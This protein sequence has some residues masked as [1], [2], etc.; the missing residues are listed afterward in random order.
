[1]RLVTG[2]LIFFMYTSVFAIEPNQW[3]NFQ[4]GTT[5]GWGS[6]APNPNPPVVIIDGG[7]S[8]TGDAYLLV[9]S[10]GTSGAGSMLITY[11]I[12][13]WSGDF[14]TAG[15]TT[16]SMHMN[17]FNS[18]ELNMRVVLQGPGGNFWSV[19]PVNLPAQS[20]WQV[21][22]FSLLPADLTGG[23]NYNATLS[24]V[25]QFR[26]IH[27]PVGSH[28][29][30]V[31]DAELGVDNITAAADPLPVELIS[32]N[33]FQ[34]NNTIGLNWV[35]ASEINNHGFEIERKFYNNIESDWRIIGFKEGYGTTSEQKTYSFTDDISG[36]NAE[37]AAY[38]LKQIDFNG[39][40]SYSDIIYVENVIPLT[41][42]LA[43]NYPNPFNPSTN[44]KFNLPKDEFVSL[45]IYNS[46]G[47]EVS[48]I[49]NET[50]TAGNY[51]VPFNASELSSGI[52][53][54]QLS[55]GNFSSTKKM[56]LLK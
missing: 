13:Q 36:L 53:Y 10:N 49:I 19:D 54:Y 40:F 18:E 31:I 39:S 34:N 8:G 30:A 24:G 20:G 12:N 55:A 38:R 42:N 32:F 47:K 16:V 26:I 5:Q 2:F 23:A 9:T 4:D 41:F 17:N 44:I 56:L 3:D 50:T 45:K 21:V 33:A 14:I 37:K 25:T 51:V 35:T 28:M 48:V 27:N 11:N 29:G 1:M 22:Q 46:L 15:V 7:P 43:Q 6:G 52:Y